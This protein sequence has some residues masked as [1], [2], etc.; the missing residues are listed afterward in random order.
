MKAD[1]LSGRLART[2]QLLAKTD[3]AIQIRPS[4]D[5]PL[6]TYPT[7]FAFPPRHKEKREE[8]D[9]RSLT[10]TLSTVRATAAKG[11]R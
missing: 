7:C 6:I 10:V 3:Q 11:G 4:E 8:V 2:R 5:D 9:A 1:T